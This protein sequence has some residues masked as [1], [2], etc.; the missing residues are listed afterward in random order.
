MSNACRKIGASP[1]VLARNATAKAEAV[2]GRSAGLLAS[3][4]I[5]TAAA[6]PDM[7]FRFSLSGEGGMSLCLAM[8]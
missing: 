5:T 3:A 7:S 8:S 1:S 4:D 6:D 2:A